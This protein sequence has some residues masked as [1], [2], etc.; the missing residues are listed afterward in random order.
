MSVMAAFAYLVEPNTPLAEVVRATETKFRVKREP[1]RV[2]SSPAV[3]S[4][5]GP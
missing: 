2:A 3:M 4:P 5:N 1:R